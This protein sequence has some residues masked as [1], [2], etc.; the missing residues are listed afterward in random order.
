MGKKFVCPAILAMVLQLALASPVRAVTATAA[1]LFDEDS[2]TVVSDS[3]GNGITGTVVGDAEW[4]TGNDA[5]FGS[6]MKFESGEYVD[7][8]APT[9]DV[10]LIR[11]D[12]TF[13]SWVKPHEIVNNWQVIFS[14]QRGS[15]GG[16]A[17][18]L[19]YGK[20]SDQLLALFNTQGGN[21][22]IEDPEAIALDEWVHAAATYD[23]DKAVLFRNGEP[24][25]ESS[26]DVGGILNHEDGLGR[27][28]INGNY[29]S[30]DG[31]LSEHCS[32]SIDEVLIFDEVLTQEDIV[33]FMEF[34][35]EGANVP[36]TTSYRPE[37][38]DGAM[39]ESTWTTLT[40]R[41]G[42]TAVSHRLYIADNVEDVD[43]GAESALQGSPSTDFMIIG[44]AGLP[45]PGG[46]V[47]GTTYYWRI[48]DVEA[49]GAVNRGDIW[50]FWIPSRRG[51]DPDPPE[52]AE[53]VGT[54]PTLTWTNGFGAIVRYVYFGTNA[55][56]VAA[57]TGAI[58]QVETT[59]NP[60]PLELGT[61]YYWRVDEFDGI[62][63]HTGDVWSFTTIP[64]IP[65]TDP[66]L[67]GW[68]K[69]DE[70]RGETVI[71]WSGNNRH[72]TV[73]GT[74]VWEPG[75]AGFD[76]A[77][78]F[79]ATRGAQCDNF[80]PTGGTGVFTLA[81]WCCWDG[82][83]S[84]QH[85]LTKSAGW[86]AETMMMQVEVKGGHSNPSR[87]DRLH[88]AYQ[89]APQAILSAIPKDEWA[90]IALTFDGTDAISFF[91]GVYDAGPQ[92]T[93]IGP[94]IDAPVWIGVAHNDARVFQGL[95]DDMRLFNKVL[96]DDEISLI[97]RGDPMVAWNPSPTNG[98]T[99]S[100]TIA[101]PLRWSPGDGASKHD[102]YFGTE[103]EAV[104]AADASD[105]TG[106]YQG[107]QNGVSFTP[108]EN[109][110]W[111]GGPYYW[112]VDEVK[113]DGTITR[114][115]LWSFTVADFLA[116]DDFETYNDLDVEE[117]D[118]NRIFAAWVD[119]YDSMT[120]GS[121][122][123]NFEA[124][125]AE[126]GIVHSG[127]QAMPFAYDNLGKTSEATKTLTS[128]RDWTAEG[129]TKLSLWY[130]GD[131]TNAD[132]R[133]FVALNGNAVVYHDDA[134]VTQSPKWTEW[135][136]DLSRFADQGV[137]LTNVK[138]ITIGFGTQG[139]PVAAG[140]AGQMYFDDIQLVR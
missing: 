34:G 97:A 118:S 35:Y 6:A 2:G 140:G 87:N 134:G 109:V 66:S 38:S 113:A 43:A 124:P 81:F 80:D 119:G 138:S 96:T 32:A 85:Y 19:T 86:G 129:V 78:N 42:Q 48:D 83:Q 17:Y 52:G 128:A 57:A 55:E 103:P 117:P 27:F 132:E 126:R 21:G 120:N 40:W 104:E 133:M 36:R 28:A 12:I 95:L 11:Q 139:S 31:G 105:T 1:W 46:L 90:H 92:P 77:L 41:P 82:T 131:S 51:Y 60:G 98:S 20:N 22:R 5:M 114:G 58:P 136:I 116:V 47:P 49:D 29:N 108:A 54:E 50:S 88:L 10:L 13:M 112:R 23:G 75:P 56:E 15:S 7:I 59:F 73:L 65:V 84:T 127:Y 93:G 63:T 72:A 69:F 53:L 99:P 4:I 62:D 115:R 123:G 89:G 76:G 102:V 111:G 130:R 100:V 9:P 25:A 3:S 110:E 39:L 24:V 91:N 67:V 94:N 64:V 14:M 70:G 33:N 121:I 44:L 125:F 107:Q 16:E 122:V 45:I 137:D 18:A 135:V 71:D 8:E 106:M 61:T 37:P 26:A 74:P 30:L 79:K 101:T 68:W